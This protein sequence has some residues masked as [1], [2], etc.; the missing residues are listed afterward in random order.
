[1]SDNVGNLILEVLRDSDKPLKA[2]EIISEINK[3]HDAGL[4]KQD[5][6]PELY[7]SLE[8][9]VTQNDKHEWSLKNA[10]KG[11]GS[12]KKKKKAATKVTEPP[13]PPPRKKKKSASAPIS[14]DEPNTSEDEAPLCPECEKP[15]VL[16]T[17]RHGRNAGNQFYGCQ[18]YPQCKGTR[19]IES[20]E[21]G[22]P[23]P[24]GT[25]N[26]S[27]ADANK[28]CPDCGAPMVRRTAS[29]GPNAGNS[30]YGCSTYPRCKTV[31]PIEGED[32]NRVVV[33]G[34]QQANFLPDFPKRISPFGNCLP[35]DNKF[36]PLLLECT[37]LPRKIISPA[38]LERINQQRVRSLC[39]WQLDLPN[40][41]QV[42]VFNDTVWLPVVEKI[43]KRG[44]VIPLSPT[45]EDE[46]KSYVQLE[47]ENDI[48]WQEILI[49]AATR[50]KPLPVWGECSQWQ[51]A[52]FDSKEE[53][54]FLTE[55]LPKLCS[56]DILGWLQRQVA[57]DGL[58]NAR[59]AEITNQQVDFLIAHPD[60]LKLVVEI[61][62]E[63]HADTVEADSR[64]DA[65]LVSAGFD[66]IRIPASEIRAGDGEMLNR[67]RSKLSAFTTHSTPSQELAF[68]EL[69]RRAHQIHL[70]LWHAL[71]MR[72]ATSEN[73]DAIP[74]ALNLGSHIDHE[75]LQKFSATVIDDFN[76]LV[77]DVASLYGEQ[78]K[79]AKFTV[80]STPQ[81]TISFETDY[82]DP[83]SETIY[84]RDIY[85][86]VTIS[87][88]IS[89]I[90]TANASN[91]SRG[92]CERLL[93]RIFGF[94]AFRDGQYEAVE[95]CLQ[96]NDAIVLLPTGGGKSIAFQLTAFLRPGICIVIDPILALIKDQIEN[97]KSHGIDRACELSSAIPRESKKQILETLSKGEYQFIYVA[98]ERFQNVEFRE[99]LQVLTTGTAVSLI[100]IDEAHC[101]SEWGHDFRPAYLNIAKTSRKY[102][103]TNG[104]PPPLMA[105]TGTASR[106]VL[107][108]VQRELDISDYDSIIT[109]TTFDRP[110][111]K[112]RTIAC[113]SNEKNLKLRG[114]LDSLPTEFGQARGNFFQANGRYT[115]A[116]LIFCPHVNG[117]FGV[118]KV[119]EEVAKHLNQ[120]VPFYSG[121]APRGYDWQ[122]YPE[123]K[124]KAALKFTRNECALMTCTKAFG[125]GIDIPNI[126]YTIH[127]GMPASIES[128]YQ[129][130]GRA[131]RD[132]SEAKCV[133]F[134]SNDAPDRNRELL[135]PT[136]TV[137]DVK[138]KTGSINRNQDDD[139]TRSL[140]FHNNSFSGVDADLQQILDVLDL[141]DDL[142]DSF[143]ISVRF[144]DGGSDD[145][146]RE[147]AI[148]RLLTIG[149]VSDY[150]LNRSA[151]EF[152]IHL[153]GSD[154]DG[155]LESL[156]DYIASYQRRQA[157]VA[158]ERIRPHL[159][160]ELRD[161]IELVVRELVEFVYQVIELS[162]RAAL[163]EMLALC[164]ECN[165]DESIRNRLLNYLG[166]S[167]FSDVI[168][169]IIDA[170]D[171]GL[172]L[173]VSAIE[174]I[175]STVDAGQ[176][177]GESARALEAYPDQ[178]GLRL[179][180]SITEALAVNP[181]LQTV[182]ENAEACVKF[183]REKYKLKLSQIISTIATGVKIAAAARPHVADPIIEGMLRGAKDQRKAARHAME[184][185]PPSMTS[186]CLAIIINNLNSK[187][188]KLVEN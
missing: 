134:Y 119:G 136:L 70:A 79:V 44:R 159:G 117:D 158:R 61:D 28:E 113:R 57:F 74:V 164:E 14:G 41:N 98:P 135:N 88:E 92:I 151:K 114:L 23:A 86:P 33:S 91:V 16:R 152:T 148:H 30:F 112:F 132:G 85:L 1:M 144:S 10:K 175:R 83:S 78:D 115:Y 50:G 94:D 183:G 15:M 107:K 143:E 182:A 185:L 162:R 150:T 108:D 84:V 59:Q 93:H 43:L 180:R 157:E 64:R 100:A 27:G 37:A 147:R 77:A 149:V 3:S 73:N 69:V 124:Q 138:E 56:P 118:V 184:Y 46:I 95:R 131:G 17:A 67:L 11:S 4:T 53:C 26:D 97:L 12:S 116:G 48:N 165:D 141:I 161:F 187:V 39:Q 140:W 20:A 120:T 137:D 2:K 126:R 34:S 71:K 7:G 145:R 174:N 121:S 129:E 47:A 122:T 96:G 188:E 177:Q 111:L 154:C 24:T 173:T 106:S 186:S 51:K 166:T 127:S 167:E 153:T 142:T 81:L 178:C 102:C 35:K 52:S 54:L 172:E 155:I 103:A 101:V 13:P 109:P 6:N 45:L 76:A 25:P 40:T 90:A 65:S 168:Q 29:H 146:E 156:C 75:I 19:D 130:A 32:G 176:L 63:Q 99:S 169:E 125:M 139:I 55:V 8:A 82:R 181:N 72:V 163:S 68:I 66:V 22:E 87:T 179:I 9:L 160:L 18:S 42:S 104:T 58:V 49:S 105:L 5:I 171:G 110:E 133:L 62:G 31:V 80:S 89:G 123:Q 128:F 36:Q 21:G 60:G 38:L 170:E